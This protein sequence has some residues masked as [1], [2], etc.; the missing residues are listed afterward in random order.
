MRPP[1]PARRRPGAG[2]F[3]L[4]ELVIA[5]AI[6]GA[7][8]AVAFGGL[9]VAVAAWTRG[10]ERA[11]VHQHLR[12]VA[13]VLARTVSAAY[14]Y[15]APAGL[16]PEPVLLFR[17]TASRLELV[18]QVPPLPAAVPAAFTAVVVAIEGDERPQ[19]VLRQRVLPNRDPFSR[20]EVVLADPGIQ[21]LELR[22]LDESGTW[23]ET[24]DAENQEGMP[25]AVRIALRAVPAAGGAALPPLTIALRGGLP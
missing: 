4:L 8:L 15:R 1:A 6:V 3:T 10:E 5:L 12:S 20:A 23:Q 2:G 16:S 9:R 17:G 7:L 24:W 25:R 13:F 22:Y 21:G 18:T 19:L 11:E 14:P